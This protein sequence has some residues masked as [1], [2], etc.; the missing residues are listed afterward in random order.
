[1]DDEIVR[2]ALARKGT[3]F[4]SSAETAFYLGLSARKLQQMRVRGL[5]PRFR[6][7][8]RVVRYHID[9]IDRWSEDS[10]RSQVAGQD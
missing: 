1:M 4:L 3:P 2:A 6:R 7:F 5:G 10:A 9:D 8:G